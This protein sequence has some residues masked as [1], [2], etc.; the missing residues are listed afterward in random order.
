ML[1]GREAELGRVDELLA[2]AGEG[3]GGALAVTGWAGIGKTTLLGA[4]ADGANARVLATTG[5]EAESSLPYSALAEL[6]DGLLDGV[7]ELPPPQ[8]AA[9]ESALAL[10]PPA[11]GDRFAVYTGFLGLLGAAAEERPLLVIVDDAHWLDRGSADCLAFAARRLADKPVAM[12]VAAR[13]DEAHAFGGRGID[14]LP[15]GGLDD[16]A[17][18]T[19]LSQRD[20]ELRP[21]V[22]ESLIE[23]AAGNPLA[24]LELPGLLTDEQR[25]GSAPL[26]KPLP[27]GISLQ[28]AFERRIGRLPEPER[29][30]LL[31][32][33]TSFTPELAPIVAACDE[34]GIEAGALE[35]AEAAGIVVLS[36]ERIEFDHPLL[37]G[38]V[39]QG[40]PAAERRRAHRALAAHTD[41]DARAWHLAAAALGEDAEAADALE[42]AGFR[43]AARG[44]H[45][46]ASEALERSARLTSDREARSRRIFATG[47]EA[48]LGGAFDRGES[49]L[50]LVTEIEDPVLRAHARRLQAMV[51]LNAG[52]RPALANHELLTEEA[53]AM[54]SLDP[55]VAATLHSDAAVT[56]AVGGACA[57]MLESAERGAELL[58]ADADPTSRCQ[59]LSMLGMGLAVH[60]RVAEAREALDEAGRLLPEVEPLSPAA[61]SISLGLGARLS[62]GQEDELRREATGLA[63]AA[64]EAQTPGLLAYYGLLAADSAYRAGDPESADQDIAESVAI[65]EESGQG[66]PLSI[67]L[68]IAARAHAAAGRVEE[69][70][71][72]AARGIELAEPVGYGSTIVWAHAA[73]G[74]CELGLDRVDEA[75]AELEETERLASA[76]GLA[77]PVSVPWEPDLVEAYCRAGRAA[78]AKR[79]SAKLSERARVCDTPLAL[80]LAARSEGLV[81]ESGFDETFERA[82][83][84]HAEATS[85]FERART[86]LAYGSKLHR[87]RRRVDARERL[88]E[89]QDVFARLGAAPWEHRAEAELRAAGAIERN[90]ATDPDAL[91]AQ[92][93]RVALAVARGATNRE[94]AAELYLSPKT[95]EFHL[96]R[97]Y[98]KLGIRS[99]T[100]LAA[101]RYDISR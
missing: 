83:A 37:R 81:S 3:R 42:A 89:A 44:A 29:E 22:A 91:T 19:L 41:E 38:A 5:L 26:E 7:R 51:T 99:R 11:P 30:A 45:A 33:A 94:V 24:L 36:P 85:P 68:V 54:A 93:L 31:T 78:D 87:A 86:L 59:V 67:G 13:S 60:G 15:L 63:A 28:R 58:P 50:E 21:A 4:V 49:L 84:L 9:L 43:A 12:L 1:Y 101:M 39:Y 23:A 2:R 97:V 90:G 69:A 32:S 76:A 17:A 47:L 65:A 70:R 82:L 14:Q 77:E 73:L 64:R 53:E 35:R 92:E 61:Q 95:I 6:A 46:A 40:A 66:G 88:R 62:T 75:I 56:A 72:E 25:A 74:F 96:G 52:S 100:E 34:L 48:A 27:P 18:R 71:A 57:L 55:T 80:A 16:A 20:G 10:G 79:V 8:A 98:R